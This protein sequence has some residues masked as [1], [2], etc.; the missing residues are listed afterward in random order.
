MNQEIG[1]SPGERV[2]TAI[3]ALIALTAGAVSLRIAAAAGWQHAA[4]ATAR[5]LLAWVNMLAVVAAHLLPA[6]S[7]RLTLPQKC[8]AATLWL[9]CVMYTLQGQAGFRLASEHEASRQRAETVLQQAASPSAPRRDKVAILGEKVTLMDQLARLLP[10]QCSELCRARILARR[11][12]VEARIQALDAE[13]DAETDQRQ[14]QL[15]V[16]LR[17]QQAQGDPLT[18]QVASALGISDEA[19]TGA[20]AVLFAFILEGVG[21]LCWTILLPVNR[22]RATKDAAEETH[23]TGRH[24]DVEERKAEPEFDGCA[25]ILSPRDSGGLARLA[26]GDPKGHASADDG[27]GADQATRTVTI[28]VP[29]EVSR[30]AS[31]WEKVSAAVHDGK[32]R[33][34]VN[35]VRRY[36]RCGQRHAREVTTYMKRY[37]GHATDLAAQK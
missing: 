5:G 11:A 1:K 25:P 26:T 18:S 2:L 9:V 21:A 33:P 7:R 28:G 16:E 23:L 22:P 6:I 36:L 30:V 20:T 27:Q 14:R 31:D 34:T 10:Q 8:V 4:D 29:R 24:D 3:T 32:I 12:S 35:D 13:A 17:A 19:T 37:N 15:R